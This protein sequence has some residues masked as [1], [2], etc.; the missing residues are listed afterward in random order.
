MNKYEYQDISTHQKVDVWHA[1]THTQINVYIYIYIYV[2][3]IHIKY[4]C[5]SY[6]TETYMCNRYQSNPEH[7]TAGMYIYDV[8]SE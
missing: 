8:I 2:Y 4:T 7:M 5:V 1:H 3:C 6:V